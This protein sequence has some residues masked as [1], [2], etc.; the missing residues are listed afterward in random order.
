MEG[1]EALATLTQEKTI[2]YLP[3]AVSDFYLPADS[4]AEHKIQSREVETLDV[5]LLP[6]PKKLGII[7]SNNPSAIAISYKL[8][9]DEAI[10]ENKAVMSL[11][12]YNMDMVIAN[13]LSN[14]R[15]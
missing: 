4:L 5:S 15:N 9:T 3:A 6:V 12:K 8:E 7:K 11:E 14:F 2:F 1:L 10:L 13:L